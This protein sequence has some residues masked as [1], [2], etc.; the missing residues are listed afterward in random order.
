M[1]H[2]ILPLLSLLAAIS[3]NKFPEQNKDNDNDNEQEQNISFT[4]S[5]NL[6]VYKESL[7]FVSTTMSIQDS[8]HPDVSCEVSQENSSEIHAGYFCKTLSYNVKDV[9][10]TVTVHVESHVLELPSGYF[11]FGF[12]WAAPV[13][14]VDYSTIMS[15]EGLSAHSIDLP[16]LTLEDID[17]DMPVKTFEETRCKSC[18]YT[19]KITFDEHPI[20]LR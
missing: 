18:D 4:V 11:P 3:C 6:P 20:I 10:V 9:P 7:S 1:K 14:I 13:P 15:P 12:T 17:T 5:Y 2:F 16:P 19:F 8:V